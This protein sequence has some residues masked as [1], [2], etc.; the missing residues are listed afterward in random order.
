MCSL[1][2]LSLYVEQGG[3]DSKTTNYTTHYVITIVKSAKRRK[4]RLIQEF[5]DLGGGRGA[6]EGDLS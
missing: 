1:T 3:T 5:A 6:K 4:Y 2:S